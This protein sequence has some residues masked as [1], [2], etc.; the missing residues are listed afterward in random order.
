MRRLARTTLGCILSLVLTVL[1]F[2]KL[3]MQE[4]DRAVASAKT[5]DEVVA[6]MKRLHPNMGMENQ[7]ANG[8]Q[9]AFRPPAGR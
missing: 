6:Q 7:L 2:M 3:Y 5:P 9:A 8:A 4:W 1:A